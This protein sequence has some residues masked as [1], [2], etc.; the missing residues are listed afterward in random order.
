MDGVL[1]NDALKNNERDQLNSTW[2]ELVRDLQC[3]ED[4]SD[5][6]IMLR[7]R[8]VIGAS[9]WMA[10]NNDSKQNQKEVLDYTDVE[11]EYI[12]STLIEDR[13]WAVPSVKDAS[14]NWLKDNCAPEMMIQYIAH[15][16]RCHIV[17]FDLLLDT[18]QFIS[19]NHLKDNDNVIFDSPLLIYSTGSHFQ[20]V[21]HKS[22]EF[23]INY[24][25]KLE[26]LNTGPE[27]SK[28]VLD[29]KAESTTD[30]I[31]SDT[32]PNIPHLSKSSSSNNIASSISKQTENMQ[33]TVEL[34]ESYI[35]VTLNPSTQRRR[36]KH[37]V[38][39]CYRYIP[40]GMQKP[41]TATERNK[42]SSTEKLPTKNMEFDR[43]IEVSNR[44]HFFSKEDDE[45]VPEKIDDS[46]TK[47]ISSS[48]P[49]FKS[50]NTLKSFEEIKS[51]KPR[52]RTDDQRK[53][54]KRLK[55]RN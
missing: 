28:H 46:G 20:S 9:E 34:K 54:L 21:F 18:V 3:F 43:G 44:Y 35:R 6:I 2:T 4:L 13:A 1:N 22:Q 10:G 7:R 25:N 47:N 26:E 53:Y 36:G 51:I 19:A 50:P 5:H 39:E 23:F 15:D 11:W 30:V 55:S 38:E 16:L 27:V 41:T 45:V 17:V 49:N 48:T 12:W 42:P 8:W 14:G 52:N 32:K 24:A 37:S 40:V 33:S 29:K 31:N